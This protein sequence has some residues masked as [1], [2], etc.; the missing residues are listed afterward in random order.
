MY[1]I[2]ALLIIAAT[3]GIIVFLLQ[4]GA[5]EIYYIIITV[6]MLT[7]SI[8]FTKLRVF[9]YEDSGEVVTI[10]LFHPMDSRLDYK[11]T[12]FPAK[13]LKNYGVKKRFQGYCMTLTLESLRKKQ[14]QRKFILLSL[15]RIQLNELL[16]SLERAKQMDDDHF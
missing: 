7:L 8:I 1:L 11:I 16:T 13:Q 14:V 3:I 2:V 4:I 9:T 15:G 5:K 12:E 10:K 6:M